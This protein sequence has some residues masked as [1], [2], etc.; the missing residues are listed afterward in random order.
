M[1]YHY[2][3]GLAVPL[4]LFCSSVA[5]SQSITSM[6]AAGAV[7]IQSGSDFST[8]RGCLKE[9]LYC[10]DCS[11]NFWVFDGDLGQFIS[12]GHHDY[13]LN[14]CFCRTDLASSATS[15]LSSCVFSKCSS[16]SVDVVSAV[17]LFTSY[18]RIT[19]ES[20]AS[21][22]AIKTIGDGAL[23]ETADSSGSGMP[24]ATTT[25]STSIASTTGP[26]SSEEQL[27]TQTLTQ[28]ITDSERTWSYGSAKHLQ[29]KHVQTYK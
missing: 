7:S 19:F 5:F 18:C 16:A 8:Q 26:T 22:T 4:L 2:I 25:V 6:P 12:C 23:G 24:A 3:P 27:I 20:P 28:I 1:I 21:N 14:S 15:Y 11:S 29:H 17:D 13:Y 10:V 9:C